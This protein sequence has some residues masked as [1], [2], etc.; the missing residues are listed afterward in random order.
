VADD[1]TPT[2]PAAAARAGLAGALA[3]APLQGYLE[4]LHAALASISDG[5][6]ADYIPELTRADPGWFGIALATVDGHVYQAGES[7]RAFT[8]Q[9]ISKAIAYGLALED[10]GLDAVLSKVGVE[11]SGEAFNSISLE[12]T[13]GRPFNPMINAGAIATTALVRDDQAPALERLLAAFARYTGRDMDIDEAVFRSERET[14]HRNRAIAHLL[15][16]YGV[17]ERSPED[18]TDIY[19]QQCSIR[20]TARDLALMGACLANGGVNPVTG[21]VALKRR[22]VDKV[23]SVMSTCGMYDY[24]GG[25]I[26]NIGMPAKSGVGGGIMAVLPGQFG[27]GVFSPPL[28]AKGNSVRGIATCERIS[29]DFGL[30]MFNVARATSATVLRR[31]YDCRQIRSR[32]ERSAAEQAVLAARGGCVRVYELQG[33]LVFGSAESVELSMLTDLGEADCLVVDCKRVVGIGDAAA[34]LLQRLAERVAAA[35]KHLYFT[36]TMHLYG[37]RRLLQK[38]NAAGS[39]DWLRFDDTDRAVEHCEQRLVDAA[40]VAPVVVDGEDLHNHYLCRGLAEDQLGAVRAAGRE[41]RYPAGVPVISVG[42][43]AQSF[44]FILA[45]EADVWVGTGGGTAGRRVRLTT[46]GPG[47]VFGE[48]GILDRERR[49]ANVTASTALTCLEVPFAGLDPA[50]R[51][52]MLAN[53]AR[54]FAGML[55]EN[56]ELVRHLS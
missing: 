56:A 43:T 49:S 26:F 21:V 19:F 42:E 35:G 9:S 36:E 51:E 48:I 23:L 24:S 7:R 25:W 30:H 20:V 15:R 27:L 41:R 29:R 16:G 14:G 32:R 28:D 18:A 47:T 12:P 33:E 8:V 1:D 2:P 38:A 46:L 34:R 55:R 13:T 50:I 37:F 6:L 10:H 54:H 3:A 4:E 11:P 17:L 22:Y 45:G 52:Q 44:F 53:M 39:A 5:A 31:S 40:G